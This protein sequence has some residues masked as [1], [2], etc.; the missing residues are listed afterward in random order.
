[1]RAGECPAHGYFVLRCYHFFQ[2][3]LH[4]GKAL[5]HPMHDGQVALAAVQGI[6]RGRGVEGRI[7]RYQFF[8]QG[9][10]GGVDHLLKLA[11]D[12]PVAL[13]E[14]GLCVLPGAAGVLAGAQGAGEGKGGKQEAEGGVHGHSVQGAG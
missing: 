10:V 3:P 8:S 11:H 5:A 4:I 2:L 9:I 7:C 1:M 6:G 14:R 12:V 13:Y